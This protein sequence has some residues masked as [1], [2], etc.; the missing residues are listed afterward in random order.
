MSNSIQP[1]QEEITRYL[2][3]DTLHKLPQSLSQPMLNNPD[4]RAKIGI[5]LQDTARILDGRVVQKHLLDTLQAIADGKK[6]ELFTHEG[7][8][9]SDAVR[10]NPDGSAEIVKGDRGARFSNVALLGKD[11]PAR[12]KCLTQLFAEG[13]FEPGREAYWRR[14][15]NKRP[16]TQ[17]EYLALET[18]LQSHPEVDLSE[19]SDDLAGESATI[20][21]LAR[22]TSDYL[23]DLIGLP[24]IP[25]S[26]DGF[27]K[28]WLDKTKR[29]KGKHLTRR[30]RLAAPLAIMRGNLIGEAAL[31]LPA[32]ERWTL[33]EHLVSSPDP[34]SVLAALEIACVSHANGKA[35][36]QA[37]NALALLWNP[38]SNIYNQGITDLHIA[39][40]S[41]TAVWA[42]ARTI[43][44][45]PLYAQ[46]LAKFTHSAHIARV[47]NE[48]DVERPALHE[49]VLDAFQYPARLSDY[50]EL[51]IEPY[52][53][54]IYLQPST[55]T[56]H[57]FRRS[58]EI[59]NV[60]PE[61]L[62]PS[63]WTDL[64]NQMMEYLGQRQGNLSL[65]AASPFSGFETN[66]NG[67]NELELEHVDGTFDVLNQSDATVWLDRMLKLQ[68]SFELPASRRED[69]REKISE[70]IEN[71]T[72]EQFLHAVEINLHIAARWRDIAFSD[73]IINIVFRRFKG[74]NIDSKSSLARQ[75]LLASACEASEEKWLER[76]Q[77]ITTLFARIYPERQR[78]DA[79][80]ESLMVIAGMSEKLAQAVA[81][82]LSM[83]SLIDNEVA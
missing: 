77:V 69:Y 72:G 74:G 75:I 40:V 54:A 35:I 6:P 56:A 62:R 49:R 38:E 16:V 80:R 31:G 7:D 8:K 53:Q 47:L 52:W 30:L 9:I 2:L 61:E 21:I 55:L 37:T 43:E 57:I 82:A 63:N 68:V 5:P 1:T 3:T 66:W 67:L 41:A 50:R 58:V 22:A 45:W 10:L 28:S 71:L 39:H 36:N 83:A 27:Q 70:I 11:K 4:L 51:Q 46:R 18:E 34:L 23:L 26:F 81:P 25:E 15:I 73:D 42:R 14:L 32:K 20:D 65:W 44:G 19:I 78:I 76:L 29:L 17:A 33:F 79:Y 59:I 12:Q 13:R 60:F 24:Q 48:H 64:G